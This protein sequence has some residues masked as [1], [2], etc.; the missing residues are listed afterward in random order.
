MA[1]GLAAV[2]L[3][4]V[5]LWALGRAWFGGVFV[6]VALALAP[7]AHAQVYWGNYNAG[8]IGR[9]T[10]T[11]M[12]V[13]ESFITA[14][15]FVNPYGVAVDGAHVYWANYTG[16]TNTIGRANLD[17][18]GVDQSFITGATA[19]GL[20]VDGAHIYWADI[21]AHTIGR[22]NLDGTDA[23]PNFIT[24]AGGACGP[25]VDGAH[26]YWGNGSGNAIGRAE[27]DGTGANPTFIVGGNDPGAVAVDGTHIY[28]ANYGGGTGGTTIGRAELNGTDVNQSFITGASGPEGVAVDG[29]H[30]YWANNGN[31]TAGTIG[32]AA[33]NGTDVN[34]SFITGASGAW[35]VAVG[36]LDTTIVAGPSGTL[37]SSAASFAFSGSEPGGF[38]CRLDGATFAACSSPTSYAGVLN[39]PH[40]FE[41]RATDTAGNVDPTPA[42]RTWTVSSPA[43][44]FGAHT[45]VTLKLA[46]SRIPA[47]GP[48][49]VQIANGNG[50]LVTGKLSAE[51]AKRVSVAHKRRIELKTKAFQVGAH[52]KKTLKLKL[53]NT[54]RRLLER[55]HKL[56]LRLTAKVKDPAAHTRTVNK[57]IS[58]RLKKN[59]R[60]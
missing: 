24:G 19:C 23:D 11:G 31:D 44:A 57:T 49:P 43:L 18:T 22:A 52:S 46:T 59:R 7:S 30:L 8:T 38:E 1:L 26:V 29:T 2:G 41:V 60:G 16:T 37:G 47:K 9:A 3:C 48:L 21:N 15:P 4:R 42:S 36:P 33:L 58:P 6:L 54:L 51:T 14:A 40:T 20:A 25:A 35:F 34:Q 45:L 28:W 55:R 56:S 53:P 27:L 10:L 17:G 12:A 39:G 5:A 13:D 50:F 32:R